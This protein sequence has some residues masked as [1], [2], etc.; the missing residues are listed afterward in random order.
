MKKILIITLF[1]IVAIS[2]CTAGGK[3]YRSSLL[4]N[5]RLEVDKKRGADMCAPYEFAMAESLVEFAKLELESGNHFRAEEYLTS[6]DLYATKASMKADSCLIKDADGDKI[7]DEKDKCPK[8]P[9]LPEFE[10]CPDKDKDGI[11]DID[12]KCI[13]VPGIKDL[14]GCPPASDRDLD[15]I[16][17]S[18]DRCPDD[19]GFA[20]F[21]GCPDRDGDGIADLEDKCPDIKGTKELSGCL[22]A[23]DRDGDT[24]PDSSDRCPDEKGTLEF[25]GCPDR[26]GDG[27]ADLEDKCPDI[28][29]TKELSGCLPAADRDGDTIP[30]SSDRCPDDKGALELKGCPDR[31]LDKIA[32][33]DDKCPD[34]PGVTELFGCPKVVDKDGDGINDDEDKCPDV[35]GIKEENGCPKKYKLIVVTAQK[36]ELKQVVYFQSGKAVIERQ[37]YEMLKEVADALKNAPSVKKVIIEGHTD[38]VGNRN[39]NVTLS[40]K[41]AESVREFLVDEGVQ[42]SKLEAKGYGPDKPIASN[43]TN[44]GKAKNRRVEFILE[45]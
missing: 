14:N 13:D 32:D 7:P 11:P 35:P 43:K 10:G 33:L 30:D 22:P 20:E 34:V 8:E 36:I 26:D 27:I 2:G 18:E 44:A 39:F 12:D 31:D 24:I 9:G 1:V 41:R 21:K 40:Q 45:Q 28:K 15:G 4:E 38:N 16:A 23:A 25:K 6:K 5:K 42:S 17:D 37:S 29:G 3:L 19:K